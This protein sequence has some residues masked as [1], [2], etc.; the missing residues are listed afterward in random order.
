M[1]HWVSEAEKT[2]VAAAL[3]IYVRAAAQLRDE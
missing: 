3:S 2:A 1:R